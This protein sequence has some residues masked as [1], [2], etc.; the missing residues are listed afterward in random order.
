MLIWFSGP[1]EACTVPIM[2]G[3]GPCPI[4]E[5]G[6]GTN[7]NPY[8][9]NSD[10]NVLYVEYAYLSKSNGSR[11]LTESLLIV[12]LRELVSLKGTVRAPKRRPSLSMKY[13]STS[14]I[15]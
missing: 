8:A 3:A 9:W 12:K 6:N 5:W 7:N 2:N 4:N 1:G 15:S 10:F 11:Y 14:S 13:R